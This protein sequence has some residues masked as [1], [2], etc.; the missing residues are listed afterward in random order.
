MKN[1]HKIIINKDGQI[2]FIYDDTLKPLL[3]QGEFQRKRASHVEPDPNSQGW[4][5]DM[6]PVGGPD[7][8]GPFDTREQALAEEVKWLNNNKIPVPH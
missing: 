4:L 7:R 8:L 6:T 3:D 5:V 2:R 1:I